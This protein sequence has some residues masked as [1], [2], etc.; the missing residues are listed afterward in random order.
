ME[1]VKKSCLKFIDSYAKGFISQE[2][3]KPR[4]TTMKQ[5]L[6]EIEE[7]K[8]RT[9]DQK[10]LQQELS[11]VTDSLKNFSSSVE[12]KLDQVDWQTKQNIIR[13]L[14]HQ[15]EINHNHLYI[16]FR[17]KSLANFDQNSHNR[18]MQCCTS[19]Q[20]CWIAG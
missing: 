14:I 13:M 1:H 11:L 4:I 8:E 10:K 7:E 3:F 2:E 5:H 19:S 16:V 6:K 20:Y 18:I 12:S 17:I 9:L 15:I